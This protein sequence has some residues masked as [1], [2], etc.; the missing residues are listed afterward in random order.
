MKS[1]GGTEAQ[2]RRA[3][4]A[5]ANAVESGMVVGLG[6]GSTAAHAIRALGEAVESGLDIVGVPTSFGARELAID[7]EIPLVGLDEVD[8]IDLAIDGADQIVLDSGNCIKG[9]GAAHSREKLVASAADDLHIVVDPTK[10]IDVL[11]H[12]VAVEVLP[13]AHTV[14]ADAIDSLGGDATLRRAS[15]KD[16][17]VVTDNGN[18]VCDAEFGRIDEPASLATD[19]ATIPGVVEHGLFVEY[20]TAVSVGSDE[21]VSTT[22]Y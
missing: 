2:K 17:P 8:G 3:G 21:G 15:D 6:T 22:T 11:D 14:V 18:L 7:C 12:T 4:E 19:L 10:T 1:T 13:D 5:A 9:G 20:A 16:G